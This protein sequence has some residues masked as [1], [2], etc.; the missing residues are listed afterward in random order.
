[1]IAQAGICQISN[2]DFT[3]YC[4]APRAPLAAYLKT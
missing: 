1:M 2:T 4:A 3:A